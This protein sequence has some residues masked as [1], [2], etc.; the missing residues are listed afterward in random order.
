[1]LPTRIIVRLCTVVF[2]QYLQR[3]GVLFSLLQTPHRRPFGNLR[4]YL[5]MR[6]SFPPHRANAALTHD[7][8]IFIYFG[9]HT[10]QLVPSQ[11]ASESTH[12]QQ[13]AP[14]LAVSP[15][16]K[17]LQAFCSRPCTP[18]ELDQAG[19]LGPLQVLFLARLLVPCGAH[20][21]PQLASPLRSG[22]RREAKCVLGVVELPAVALRRNTAGFCQLSTRT[23]TAVLSRPPGCW[24]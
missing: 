8:F 10:H 18:A 5:S 15:L 17:P 4:Q 9:H 11:S 22:A 24:R 3:V 19:N 20:P 13:L 6:R 1:M 2:S 23:N 21:F 16:I 7:Y 12:M 14:P